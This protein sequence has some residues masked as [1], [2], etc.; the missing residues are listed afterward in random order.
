MRRLRNI[1]LFLG[2][3]FSTCAFLAGG[4]PAMAQNPDDAGKQDPAAEGKADPD[5]WERLI[6]IP[7]KNLQKVLEDQNSSVMLPYIEYIKLWQAAQSM[8]AKPA[9]VPAV[10]TE[11]HYVARID[12]DVA[13]IQAELHIKV[14]GKNWTEVPVSFGQAAVGKMTATDE[15]VLLRGTGN[16]TYGLLFP[17]EGQY[18]VQ[19]ELL[20]RVQTSPDGRRFEMNSPP[21]AI[22]TLEVV[23]PEAD[24]TIEVTPQQVALP[25]EAAEG[26]TR[27]KATL[28]STQLISTMWHPRASLK[29][30]MELLASVT[31][32]TR[33]MYDDGLIRTDAFLTYEVLRGEMQQIRL[34][35]PR[36]DRILDITSPNAKV[37]SWQAVEEE[38]RQIITV[39][40]L[41]AIEK[42]VTI[43]AHTERPAPTESASISGITE[44]GVVSGIHA[45]DAVR[46]SGQLVVG[47]SPSITLAIDDQSG[48]IR[49]A[50]EDIVPHIRLAGA[51]Y[52]KFYSPQ[53]TLKVTARPVQPH[54][55]VDHNTILQFDEDEIRI[56][57]SLSFLIEQ[58][59]I[60]DLKLK[61][62]ENVE[63]EQVNGE[64]VKEHTFD[65]ATR[66]LT[67]VLSAKSL[68]SVAISVKSRLPLSSD[69]PEAQQQL[70]ILEPLAVARENG[71][72]NVF[73][74]ESFEIITDEEKLLAAQPNP[75]GGAN[76]L[77]GFRLASAWVYHRRPVEIWV[78][79]I[80]KPTRLTA[81]L[82]TTLTIKES[83]VEVNH[84]L[85]YTVQ[86]AGV[87]TFLFSVP[88]AVAGKVQVRSLGDSSV[89]AIKQQ[90]K[91]GEV[92]DGWV[93]W[94][95]VLQ[96]EYVGAVP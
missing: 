86:Y 24:Q 51:L 8:H 30:E 55:V 92:I 7:F 39:E 84:R 52:F 67:V 71:S 19:L 3:I 91:T 69:D 68:G 36:G 75:A 42:G 12:Q 94:T 23:I 58:A 16:G 96:R 40:F 32:Q 47:N 26:E 63:V 43:E 18:T 66:M 76:A 49:V 65:A 11:A 21:V 29:P 35:V 41:S 60:F 80:R 59:G 15:A 22:T 87:D 85:T 72:V 25:V 6:Y 27:V 74:P 10:I 89:P 77:P 45:L 9:D 13:R 34:V 64:L 81:D 90:S 50:E 73:A 54:V 93:T 62:P 53:Y 78:K 83:L 46:E 5:T 28:G 4:L 61:V 82:G 33:I 88:E 17:K 37:K 44:A 14:L 48:L 57:S 31:N 2:V 38:N 56:E 79:T 95:V 70:P 20:A 1:G